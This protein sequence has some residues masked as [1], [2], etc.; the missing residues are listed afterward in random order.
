MTDRPKDTLH[1][2]ALRNA[3]KEI[4]TL[5]TDLTLTQLHVKDGEAENERL[6]LQLVAATEREIALMAHINGLKQSWMSVDN[7]LSDFSRLLMKETPAQSLAAH[8]AALWNEAADLCDTRAQQY[9]A[10][11]GI[12]TIHQQ[13]M[14]DGMED[15][16]E[17]L[18]LKAD[19]A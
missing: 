4:D 2:H 11:T 10:L 3:C 12:A 18:R 19:T 14:R 9:E 8:D 6:N 17:A 15:D 7:G 5:K 1:D 13:G 16:A